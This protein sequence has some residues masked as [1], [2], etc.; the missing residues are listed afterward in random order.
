MS[1][2][3]K[4]E[5]RDSSNSRSRSRDALSKEASR[6]KNI[7]RPSASRDSN[8]RKKQIKA[9]NNLLAMINLAKKQKSSVETINLKNLGGSSGKKKS[10]DS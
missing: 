3:S 8:L 5:Q 4:K 1:K 2:K 6:D 9:S 10:V 7:G